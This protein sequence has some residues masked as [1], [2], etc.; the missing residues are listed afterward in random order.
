MS[1][2]RGKVEY[3]YWVEGTRLY[4]YKVVAEIRPGLV[5]LQAPGGAEFHCANDDE[6]K[7]TKKEAWEAAAK[8]TWEAAAKATWETL[9]AC[10]ADSN[11][12]NKTLAELEKHLK[13]QQEKACKTSVHGKCTTK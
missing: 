11:R 2:T 13:A 4:T 5:C 12:L 8:A 9:K 10:Y 1:A 7:R 3:R 6:L